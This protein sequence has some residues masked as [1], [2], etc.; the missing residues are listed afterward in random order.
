M[1]RRIAR[2]QAGG[3]GKTTAAVNPSEKAPIL[4]SLIVLPN[5]YGLHCLV[6]M[7]LPIQ[8][9]FVAVY[10]FLAVCNLLFLIV[11]CLRWFR[12]MKTLT[13]TVKV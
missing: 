11:G 10:T 12:E 4:R 3:T 7:L 1:L 5:D 9:T 2:V 8:T 6:L 13:D